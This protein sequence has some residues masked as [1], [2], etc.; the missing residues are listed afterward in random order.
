MAVL[1]ITVIIIPLFIYLIEIK[2]T[3]D[4]VGPSMSTPAGSTFNVM[5]NGVTTIVFAY[6]GQTVFPEFMSQMKDTSGAVASFPFPDN[7]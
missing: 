1:G 5:V 6:Q 3:A 2:R 4:A 7:V